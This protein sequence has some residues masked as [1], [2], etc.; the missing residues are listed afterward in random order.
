MYI[1]IGDAYDYYRMTFTEDKPIYLYSNGGIKLYGGTSDNVSWS[2]VTSKPSLDGIPDGSTRKLSDYVKYNPG[3]SE[4]TIKS[5][6]SSLSK[7]VV[8]LWRNSGDYYTF[9]GFSNGT[10]ETYLGGIGF[11]SQSDSNLYRKDNSGNY[12]KILD[13]NNWT[14]VVDGRYLKLS[15]GTMTGELT[16]NGAPTSNLHAAT[17]KYVDDSINALPEPMLFKGSLGTGGTITSLPTAAAANEGFTYKVITAGTYA[18]QAAKIGDTFISDGSNWVLI[19]SGDEPSGTVTSVGASGSGGITVSGSPVTTSGT[20]AIGLNLSTAINGLGEGSRN[21]TRNDY[22]VAQYAGGGTT[23]TTYHR[24]KLSNIFAALNSSDITTAL[25][26]TPYNST[27][28]NGYTSNTGTVT[29]ITLKATSPIA[30]DSTAAITTSGT[31]TF[32]HSNSGVTAGTYESVTVNA[33]GHVT[34]GTNPTKYWANVQVGSS[35]N[36]NTEP[37][38]KSVKINGSTTNS[39]SSANALL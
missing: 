16:L 28:P 25:G 4:Q 39:A 34:A 20:I 22:I 31:R 5:S 2:N 18:N 24:R 26:Y 15:G 32:S 19:P 23:T 11:K 10:T 37:E 9:L 3:A 30:I 36:Y 6:I 1:Y 8:N 21:A 17:K 29:S 7:G 38:L 35:T 12:Y 13:E 14:G 33:T 27:N